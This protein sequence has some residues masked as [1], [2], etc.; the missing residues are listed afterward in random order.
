[1]CHAKHADSVDPGNIIVRANDTDILVILTLNA[2]V[3]SMSHLWLDAGLDG[4]N[5]RT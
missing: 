5:S 4:D 2:S 1:M 3:L